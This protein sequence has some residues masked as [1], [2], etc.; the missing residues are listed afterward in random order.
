MKRF[1]IGL[2]LAS[3]L[4]APSV[5]AETTVLC[6]LVVEAPAGEIVKSEGDCDHRATS[7]STFKLAIAL[8][9][10]DAGILTDTKTPEMPFRKGYVDWRPQWRHV[11]TPESWMRESVVWYSQRITERLGKDR[12]TAYVAAFGYGN[13]D[14]S[15]DPGKDNGLTRSWLS[16]SLQISPKEQVAFLLK[17]VNRELPVSEKAYEMTARLSDH[18]TRPSG[19][20]VHGKTGAGLPVRADGSK[21]RGTPYGWFV[22][23]AE[24]DGR[25]VVFAR[26]VKD[27]ERRATPP[28]FRARDSVLEALFSQTG[29]LK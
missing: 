15:G 23:W 8:M 25:T 10:Y 20:H 7:A 4:F 13:E 27:S 12:F 9:G 2:A 6:T 22:G 17:L 5:N 14:V 19:W 28:G 21:V 18:G 11:Q 3:A 26:L 24:R 16:S 1:L 29:S